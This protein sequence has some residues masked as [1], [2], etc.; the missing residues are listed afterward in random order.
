MVQIQHIYYIKVAE[1][2]KQAYDI[3]QNNPKIE[4]FSISGHFGLILKLMEI[5]SL[6]LLA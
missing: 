5:K 1:F 4:H 3:V 6:F 2:R